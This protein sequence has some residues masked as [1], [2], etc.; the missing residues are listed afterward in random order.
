MADH[1]PEVDTS[2]V[3]ADGVMERELR[4]ATKS[5]GEIELFKVVRQSLRVRGELANS[6]VVKRA[7]SVIWGNVAEFFEAV[8]EAETLAGLSHDDPIVNHHQRMLANFT[9]IADINQTL[10]AGNDAE[11]ELTAVDQMSHFT[12]DEEPL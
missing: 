8:T 10:K 6:E 2:A 4:E 9:V 11:R 5:E 12:E 1:G 3:Y 7:L